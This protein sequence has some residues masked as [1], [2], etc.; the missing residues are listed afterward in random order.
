M[1]AIDADK[2]IEK[3]S[4]GLDNPE[5]FPVISLGTVMRMIDGEEE[6]HLSKRVDELD[7]AIATLVNLP[8]VTP[9]QKWI[10]CS[11]RLPDGSEPV[12][13]S[14]SVDAKVFCRVLIYPPKI[15]RKEY[16]R[17]Q[18]EAW[19]PLPEPYKESEGE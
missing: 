13:V 18:A 17:G 4:A 16:E 5:E 11:E 2:L 12:L 14:F 9:K 3:L 10:P 8:S 19:M 1:R 15:V 7:T 6:V